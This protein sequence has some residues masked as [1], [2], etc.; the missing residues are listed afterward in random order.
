MTFT[1]ETETRRAWGSG[2]HEN[3]HVWL[4]DD[5]VPVAF[6]HVLYQPSPGYT[7]LSICDIEVR[8][9]RR[10]QGLA[11]KVIEAAEAM[12]PGHRVQSSGS[13]TPLGFAALAKT[14]PLKE[15]ERAEV[16]FNDMPFVHDWDRMVPQYPL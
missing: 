12:Y 16:R 5:G 3:R 7:P 13:Y 6:I 10:G 8:P 15:G 11:R 4:L 14:M 1:T 2:S 9:G